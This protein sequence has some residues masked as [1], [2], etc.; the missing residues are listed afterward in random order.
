MDQALTL[1]LKN[2]AIA[3][4]AE[5][6]SLTRATLLEESAAWSPS[7][8]LPTVRAIARSQAP[9]AR[10]VSSPL[11]A[12][13]WS[14]PPICQRLQN[15]WEKTNQ[16]FGSLVRQLLLL[17]LFWFFFQL[18]RPNFT[19]KIILFKKTG[20]CDVACLPLSQVFFFLLLL[21]SSLSFKREC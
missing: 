6:V 7:R 15:C 14:S 5:S 17:L 21:L 18:R 8:W 3:P 9:T 10:L 19:A 1:C 11:R 12:W 4:K 16:A 2:W 13:L 20:P